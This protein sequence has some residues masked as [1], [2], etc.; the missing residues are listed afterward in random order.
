MYF[1]Q[2]LDDR[3]GCASYLIASGTT[4][5]A[6]VIDPGHDLSQYERVLEERNLRLRYVI[7]THVHADHISGARRLAAAHGADLCLHENAR[8]AFPFRRLR[9]GQELSLGQ[10]RLRIL[11]T[12]GHRPELVSIQVIDLERSIEG[13]YVL[14][15]DSLLVGDAGRPDFNGGDPFAQFDSI[16]RLLTLPEW[17]VV[18]PGHFEGAC[19][20]A[21]H[22]AASTTIGAERRFNYLARLNRAEF[23]ASLTGSIPPRPLNITA[24]EATNRGHADLPWAMLTSAAAVPELTVEQFAAR[25]ETAFIV[26]V[27]EPSEF[28]AAHVPGAVNIPQADLAT[29]LD[30]LPRDRPLVCICQAG[31]RSLRAAQ[32]LAQTGFTDVANVQGGAS[33]WIESGCP[34][35]SPQ[36]EL[37]TVSAAD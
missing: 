16:Q 2:F 13:L 35:I 20:A 19:G 29:R 12:P 32:F 14:T 28:L 25:A 26:D 15:G 31:R 21:M 5:E 6:A 4:S 37:E 27:R 18:Y 8:T 22:G 1:R 11:H 30:E 36:V 7:D 9:D 17:V 23:V 3:L 24:I 10:I 33:A 34:T